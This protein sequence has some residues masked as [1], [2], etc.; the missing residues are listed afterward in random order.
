MTSEQTI[1]NLRYTVVPF[2]KYAGSVFEE[3]PLNYL[4]QTISSM[5][6]CYLV[7]SAKR[8]VD[9]ASEFLDFDNGVP[10]IAWKNS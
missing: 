3:I 2:G 9:A 4:D 10:D 5:P 1:K 7:R 6:D 8:F